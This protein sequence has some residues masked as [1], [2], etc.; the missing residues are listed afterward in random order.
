MPRLAITVHPD[1]NV[2]T[3][4]DDRREDLLTLEGLKLQTA[5]AFGHKVALRNIDAGEGVIKYG[6][7][8]GIATE[9]IAAGEHVHVHNCR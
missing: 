7:V 1:D 4:L 9:A 3:L 5:V 8:I 2:T 6:A